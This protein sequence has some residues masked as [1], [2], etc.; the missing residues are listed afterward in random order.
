MID[1]YIER[2]MT[3]CASQSTAQSLRALILKPSVEH[4]DLFKSEPV[5][6]AGSSSFQYHQ[7]SHHQ[8]QAT[9]LRLFA[10]F[11]IMPLK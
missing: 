1:R 9:L 5:M 6:P 2:S 3:D 10:T 7:Y 11:N 8:I 4:E